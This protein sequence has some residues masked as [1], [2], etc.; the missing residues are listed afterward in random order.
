[1][2]SLPVPDATTLEKGPHISAHNSVRVVG[3]SCR[4]ASA[5]MKA[6]I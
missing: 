5:D 6:D 1:L 2:A 3:I 4:V